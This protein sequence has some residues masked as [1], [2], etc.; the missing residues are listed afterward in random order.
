MKGEICMATI[1]D[2]AKAAGVSNTTVTNVIHGRTHKVSEKTIEKIN[3]I[4]KDFGYVPNMSARALAAGSSKVVAMINHLDPE[5]S[6]NFLSDPFH[7]LFIGA[8]EDALRKSGYYLMFRT[9]SRVEELET[10]LRNWNV[11]GLFLTGVFEDDE[12]YSFLCDLNI[13]IV[14]SDSYLSSNEK[15]VNVGLEDMEGGRL[16]AKYLLDK[17]HRK[18][19]FACPPLKKG[20]VVDQRLEGYKK[21]L[22]ER[23]V[24]F[25]ESLVFECEFSVTKTTQLGKLLAERKDITAVFATADILAAG[26]MSGLQLGGR[27]APDNFSVI[28]FDDINW[29]RMTNPMLTT[30]KQDANKKGLLAADMMV[31]LL[32]GKTLRER[33]IVLPVELVERDSV[34]S[35]L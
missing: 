25:D 30:I 21:A 35:P 19:A 33:N 31:K 15:L 7:T 14:V 34:S 1:E 16:A 28:G 18:I 6:G 26:I 22:S 8:I 24:A 17:G 11:T 13:P 5:K 12:L 27:S 2:I 9:V 10:F 32:N 3:K 4:I 20:G 23:G 29:C